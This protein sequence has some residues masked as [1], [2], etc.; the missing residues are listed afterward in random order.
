MQKP[1]SVTFYLK[2]LLDL[3]NIQIKK[4]NKEAHI[5]GVR[6]WEAQ[7]EM[8]R[9]NEYNLFYWLLGIFLLLINVCYIVF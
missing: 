2:C 5:L 6:I 9:S 4:K 3:V 7:V 8:Q 1:L